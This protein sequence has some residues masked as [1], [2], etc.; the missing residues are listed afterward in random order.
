MA[1]VKLAKGSPRPTK[2]GLVSAPEVATGAGNP[3]WFSG[4]NIADDD[5]S[6]V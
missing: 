2:V 6:P 3:T 4:T 1:I 5:V